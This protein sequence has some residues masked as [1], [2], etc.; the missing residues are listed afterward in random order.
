MFDISNKCFGL[1][2]ITIIVLMQLYAWGSG[3]NGVVFAFTSLVV[4]S[5]VGVTLGFKWGTK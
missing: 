3:H 5:I 1:I 4:G 2:A